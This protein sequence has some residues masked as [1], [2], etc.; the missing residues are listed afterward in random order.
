M[1]IDDA[2][3]KARSVVEQ[4]EKRIADS[5]DLTSKAEG[6][7]EVAKSEVDMATRKVENLVEKEAEALEAVKAAKEA[8]KAVEAESGSVRD[9]H[10]ENLKAIQI[11]EDEA[12]KLT[13]AGKMNEARRLA[14]EAAQAAKQAIA[15]QKRMEAETAANMKKRLEEAVGGGTGSPAKKATAMKRKA[16]DAQLSSFEKQ[17]AER[18]KLR[19]EQ[20]KAAGY[21]K[22]KAKAKG[23]GKSKS[24]PA[25]A[26][27]PR[28]SNAE[29]VD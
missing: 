28:R 20:A 25:K 4:A 6:E 22:A 2:L 15:D 1:E 7:V 23:K 8:L 29:D 19:A 14:K 21:G 9:A 17:R 26:Q 24:S 5:S 18:D 10:A 27:T 12:E 3:A 13:R 11:L 16:P